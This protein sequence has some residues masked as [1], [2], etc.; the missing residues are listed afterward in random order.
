VYVA[1]RAFPDGSTA[2]AY[3][4]GAMA[5]YGV[6]FALLQDDM[7]R[8]LSYH[9][10][11][12]VG[13]MLAGVGLGGSLA[14]AGGFAHVF[15]HVLYKGLL[16]MGAGVVVY[17]T[18]ENSLKKLGGLRHSMPVTFAAFTVAALSISAFPGFNGFVSKGMIVDAAHETANYV[19]LGEDVLWWLLILGGVGTFMSFIKF[20]YYAF[21]GDE[22]SHDVADANT[23][24]KVVLLCMAGACVLLGLIPDVLFGL[25]PDAGKELHPYSVGHLTEGVGLA[26][27]G[28]VGF[29]GVRSLLKRVG[30]V[31]DV[32]AV[33]NPVAFYG[34][35][36]V[37]RAT[38]R[39]Y[40]S[41]D[42]IAVRV[43]RGAVEA[44]RDP[45]GAVRGLVPESLS[46]GYEGRVSTTPGDTGL[47]V[48]LGGG[49]LVVSLVLTALL[50]VMMV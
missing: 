9:I 11:A 47:R 35:R 33:Y 10:Q 16:F 36:G 41:A 1:Y 19:L 6:V 37:V 40:A 21:L 27:A 20:E 45:G 24:Q 43:A 44:A 34:T 25:L 38:T 42:D 48:G 28:V 12:Q 46:E 14:V 29:Y 8:L 26:V 18:G 50:V 39:V 15:N 2:L 5:V 22:P 13:Y 3:M 49:I 17:R 7:R 32:D 23:G 4:G 31:P 30:R